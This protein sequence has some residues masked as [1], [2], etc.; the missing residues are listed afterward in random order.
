MILTSLELLAFLIIASKLKLGVNMQNVSKTFLFFVS[1]LALFISVLTYA[2]SAQISPIKPK[3]VGGEIATEGDWPWMSAL[4]YTFNETTTTLSVD[5]INY[6]SQA[7]SGGVA[8]TATGVIVDCGIGDNQC[9]AATGNICLIERGDINFSVKVENCQAGGGIGAIIYNNE[10]GLFNGT[11]GDDFTGSI[12]ALAITQADGVALI[13]IVGST[14]NLSVSEGVALAQSST[15]GASFLG[16]KWLLTAAHC[17]DGVS[18]QQ[19][20]VNVGEY[21]LSNGAENAQSV[22]RIYI[23]PNYEQDTELNNDI[24]LIEL[25][26]SVNNEAV[27]LI[28]LEQ[29]SLLAMENSTATVTG[30]GGREGYAPD[31]GP[32][33]DFPDVL[34]QVD[35]QLMTNDTCKVLWL[36]PILIYLAVIIHQKV[37]V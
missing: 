27:T 9:D 1:T 25:T 18:A 6:D 23:H 12:P 32:T 7:F 13:A 24:A 16:D 21:D 19:L 20:K 28:N 3:I 36:N 5:N 29:T 34:H 8:G 17:V 15:C 35:L 26:N 37:L 30:W 11:L 22:E 33:S 14:A 4:V 10:E 2:T 31:G